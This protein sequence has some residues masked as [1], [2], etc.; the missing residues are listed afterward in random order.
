MS[1]HIDLF[2]CILVLGV[3]DV[4]II[5]HLADASIESYDLPCFKK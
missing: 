2:L 5:L 3:V 4:S 1:W